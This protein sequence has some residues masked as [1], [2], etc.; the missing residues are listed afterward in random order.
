[1]KLL[2]RVLRFMLVLFS[3][4]NRICVAQDYEEENTEEPPPA[5]PPAAE[6]CNGIYVSYEFLSRTKGYPRLKNAT[7]QSWTFN[8]TATVLNTGTDELKAWKIYIGFQHKEILVSA[9]GAVLIG[10]DSFPAPVGNGTYLSGSP[11]ADLDTSINTATDFGQMQAQIKMSGTMFGVKPPGIPMPKTIKLV[12]DGYECPAPTKKSESFSPTQLNS[13]PFLQ[14]KFC[15]MFICRN[16][17]AH[18]LQKESKN[19]DQKDKN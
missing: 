12:N 13:F 4:R 9:S 11:Q 18:L 15:G 7:A 5:P 2:W 14:S 1:M 19:E 17:N 16:L 3:L 6:N 10:G 8:S